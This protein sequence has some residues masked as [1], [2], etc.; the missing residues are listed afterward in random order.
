MIKEKKSAIEISLTDF[1]DF[2][3]KAGSSKLTK[4]KQIKGRDE[5]SPATD[6]YKA[7]R[8]GII[9]NHEDEGTKK[10]LNDILS[11]LSDPKKLKNYTEAVEG[12][13][14]FW[15]RK[16]ITWFKPPFRHWKVG[17]V[18]VRINPELG[19]EYDNKFFV[20]KLYLKSD[21][22]SKDKIDQ[23]LTLME[24]QLRKKTEPEVK[25]AVLDVKNAKLF[26]KEDDDVTLLP[27]LDG[28][29]RSFET[30]WNSIK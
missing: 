2:V 4:V 26:V 7:L 19:I 11:G 27:L 8:Q 24:S 22:L 10:D 14:K 16:V 1:V 6:F 25:M 28:E 21:K 23:I 3:C 30:I 15:G 9:S 29:A 12:Y 18:D 17:D 5:Y 20:T 13:K